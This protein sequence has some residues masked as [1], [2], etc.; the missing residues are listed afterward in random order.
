MFCDQV[1]C[2]EK[3]SV[4]RY[5]TR[6]VLPGTPIIRPLWWLDPHDVSALSCDSQFLVGDSLLVA[7]ILEDKARR[8]DVYLPVGSWRDN[9]RGGSLQGPKMIKNYIVD[10]NEIATFQRL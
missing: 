3:K 1:L 10:L 7:P 2:Q 6:R 5:C 8:R 4:P 9:L